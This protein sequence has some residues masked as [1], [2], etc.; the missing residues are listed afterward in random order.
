[1]KAGN[2]PGPLVVQPW[3]DHSATTIGYIGEKGRFIALADCSI[4]PDFAVT[5][6]PLARVLA[7][8]PE[9][10]SMVQQ[11]IREACTDRDGAPSI[12]T[13]FDAK[14]L[15]EKATGQVADPGVAALPPIGTSGYGAALIA[16]PYTHP[17]PKTLPDA[18]L[19]LNAAWNQKAAEEVIAG[20]L[21]LCRRLALMSVPAADHCDGCNGSGESTAMTHGRGPEDYDVAVNCPKCGGSGVK[22][23]E[24]S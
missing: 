5:Y 18:V 23:G 17:L 8:A 24:P 15:V 16:L 21:D 19:S 14:A 9:L 11:L 6:E 10:L 2:V 1:M 4:G 13:L 20:L 22:T 3:I 7:A 12:V